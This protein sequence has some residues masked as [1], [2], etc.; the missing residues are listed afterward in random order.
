MYYRLGI[1][2]IDIYCHV[3]IYPCNICP[4]DKYRLSI[5]TVYM[6]AATHRSLLQAC[7]WHTAKNQDQVTTVTATFVHATIVFTQIAIVINEYTQIERTNITKCESI[8]IS[9]Q[10][11][12][13]EI[14]TTL[15][16]TP[17]PVLSD[18]LSCSS[19][20]L[21]NDSF[22]IIII[23]QRAKYIS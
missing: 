12:Y 6:S 1:W 5:N 11:K 15:S 10:V 8:F 2:H 22:I 7:F 20:Y 4:G 3:D 21:D 23:S 17:L 18:I 16:Q 19:Y 14:E 9:S 13:S